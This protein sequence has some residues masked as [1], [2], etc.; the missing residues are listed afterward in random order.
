MGLNGNSNSDLE[1][2]ANKTTTGD[3]AELAN[4][5]N[6]FFLSVSDPLPRLDKDDDVFTVHEELPDEFIIS[7]DYPF[8]ALRK[9][10]TNTSADPDNIPAWVLKSINQSINQSTNQSINQSINQNMYSTH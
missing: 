2:L 10:N 3:C 6:E 5:M 8:S 4:I 9:V 1:E 7:V